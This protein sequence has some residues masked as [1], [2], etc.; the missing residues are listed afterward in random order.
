MSPERVAWH[1]DS[2]PANERVTFVYG[3]KTMVGNGSPLLREG[4][5]LHT[6]ACNAS[7]GTQA[8]VNSDGDFLVVPVE[9]ALDIQTELGK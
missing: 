3:I 2:A 6:Y 4:V 8:F 1:A 7:M 5:V 9:G